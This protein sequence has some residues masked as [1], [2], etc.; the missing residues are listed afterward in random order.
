MNRSRRN[1]VIVVAT[2][3]VLLHAA[4]VVAWHFRWNEPLPS[5][6]GGLMGAADLA[7]VVILIVAWIL[8]MVKSRRR[9]DQGEERRRR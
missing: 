2:L 7:A 4:W 6:L 9:P 5:V 3:W 8:R 1:I